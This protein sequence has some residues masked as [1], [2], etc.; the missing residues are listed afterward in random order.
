LVGTNVDI[1]TGLF[2]DASGGWIGGDDSFYEYLIKMYVYD[3]TRFATYRDRWILAADSTIAHLASNPSTRPDLTFVAQF[4]GQELIFQ[5]QHLACFDGGNFILGGLVLKE[6]KYIDFGLALVNG[7]HDTYVS[8]LTGIGP[9][10]FRWV[11]K[12]TAAND[13][14]N[15]GPSA[16]QT[17][18]YDT[19]GFYI[20]DS[21]YILRPEVLESFYYAYRATGDQI[22]RDWAW[23]AFLAIN[24]TCSV[25]SGFAELLDVNAVHGGGYNDFQDSFLF[26][27]VMKYSYLIQAP[28]EAWQVEN[29]GV[30]EWVFNTEAHPFKVAGPAI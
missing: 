12:T 16:S 27:E 11:T 21:V 28:E 5:S 13:T 8:T 9:E 20:T 19:A 6:Q 10:V 2:Q 4:E 29:G 24:N 26:A 14:N 18:F 3:S 7:C 15:P 17:A 22:Y 25:G 30:N 23:N 1:N